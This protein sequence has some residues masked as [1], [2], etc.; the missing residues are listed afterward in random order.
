MFVRKDSRIFGTLFFLLRSM[1][2]R[3]DSRVF[4]TLLFLLRGA[5][6][7]IRRRD[8]SVFVR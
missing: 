8:M 5:F 7:E 3:K 4:G 2:A 1:F 6:A